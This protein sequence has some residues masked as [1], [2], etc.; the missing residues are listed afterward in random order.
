M[1]GFHISIKN[2]EREDHE[3]YYD[4]WVGFGKEQFLYGS[5]EPPWQAVMAQEIYSWK[6]DSAF[7]PASPVPGGHGSLCHIALLGTHPENHGT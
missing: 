7:F 5:I 2:Q 3:R 4:N 1:K 6:T